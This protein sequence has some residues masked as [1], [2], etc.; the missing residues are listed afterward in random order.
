MS[1]GIIFAPWPHQSGWRMTDQ[2]EG[3]REPGLILPLSPN[4]DLIRFSSSVCRGTL[5]LW[6]IVNVQRGYSCYSMTQRT[7]EVGFAASASLQIH[8]CRVS[9]LLMGVLKEWRS[10]FA[11]FLSYT[12]QQSQFLTNRL[13]PAGSHPHKLDQQGQEQRFP[14]GGLRAKSGSQNRSGGVTNSWLKSYI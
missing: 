3:T 6:S 7:T 4:D 12:Q 9:P 10:S 2:F 13:K 8:F 11:D 1:E 5:R 14:T